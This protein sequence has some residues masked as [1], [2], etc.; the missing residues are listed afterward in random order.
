MRQILFNYVFNEHFQKDLFTENI[1]GYCLSHLVLHIIQFCRFVYF[2]LFYGHTGDK[3]AKCK[4]LL[5]CFSPLFSWIY[6]FKLFLFLQIVFNVSCFNARKMY[7]F[8]LTQIWPLLFIH[9]WEGCGPSGICVLYLVQKQTTVILL[10]ADG[11]TQAATSV[12][13]SSISSSKFDVIVTQ[14][15]VSHIENIC[16]QKVKEQKMSYWSSPQYHI[17]ICPIPV[18][19]T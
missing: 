17:L 14:Y 7:Q 8:A 18:Y 3:S 12:W 9:M 13:T 4:Y 10:A 5:Q 19:P 11:S 16:W 2:V 1:N 6:W 15:R